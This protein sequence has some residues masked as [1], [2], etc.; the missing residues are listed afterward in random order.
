M[1]RG[2]TAPFQIETGRWKGVPQHQ[3]STKLYSEE[4]QLQ[5]P[6]ILQALSTDKTIQDIH[7]LALPMF[8]PNCIEAYNL[9][10]EALSHKTQ[11]SQARQRKLAKTALTT[12]HSETWEQHLHSLKV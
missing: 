1:L 11:V 3:V 7:Q 5:L 12:L 10:K 2:G 8:P 6:Y 9:A 4:A